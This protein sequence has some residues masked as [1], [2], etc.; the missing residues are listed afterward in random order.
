[1][2][3]HYDLGNLE[4]ERFIC[5][6]GS[7]AVRIPQTVRQ[8]PPIQ[9]QKENQPGRASFMSGTSG[10]GE[11]E[12]GQLWSDELDLNPEGPWVRREGRVKPRE[13]R[14]AVLATNVEDRVIIG[15]GKINFQEPLSV[16][17]QTRVKEV[18]QT[19]AGR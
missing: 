19:A 5:V 14:C 9:T 2:I 3:K 7:R 16:T 8:V 4:E 10:R 11:G 12:M 1:M 18:G 15:F 13:D 17:G 6:D